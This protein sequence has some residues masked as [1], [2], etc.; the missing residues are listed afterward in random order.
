MKFDKVE[1]HLAFKDFYPYKKLSKNFLI[2][3]FSSN[4]FDNQDNYEISLTEN[5]KYALPKINEYFL[6]TFWGVYNSLNA[7]NTKTLI[8]LNNTGK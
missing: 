7:S 2:Q 5:I 8:R 3:L 1:C 6:M 4:S